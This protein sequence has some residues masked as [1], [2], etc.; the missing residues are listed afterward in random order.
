MA[1]SSLGINL[2]RATRD[3]TLVRHGCI[4]STAS[5]DQLA[6]GS[7][8]ESRVF[9]S[10]LLVDSQCLLEFLLTDEHNFAL[11]F[12]EAYRRCLA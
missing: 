7:E 1:N 10:E 9:L 8:Y 5:P 6:R 11:D 4:P 2:L 12:L 3:P